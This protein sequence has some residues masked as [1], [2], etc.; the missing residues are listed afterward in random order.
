VNRAQALATAAE[1]VNSMIDSSDP[2]A[3][4][5]RVDLILKVAEFLWEPTVEHLIP[6]PVRPPT[7]TGPTY[8]SNTDTRPTSEIVGTDPWAEKT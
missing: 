5:D 1:L 4:S 6:A 7:W 8:T 2:E 3:L